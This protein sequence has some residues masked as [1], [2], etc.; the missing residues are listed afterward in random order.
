MSRQL[1]QHSTHESNLDGFVAELVDPSRIS[2]I[3]S[4]VGRWVGGWVGLMQSLSLVGD[5][6]ESGI[7]P[8]LNSCGTAT[9]TTCVTMKL[10]YVLKI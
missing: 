4:W 5:L 10:D 8:R 2:V 7:M 6:C 3:P 1:P 9:R